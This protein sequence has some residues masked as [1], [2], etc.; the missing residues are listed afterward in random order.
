[1]LLVLLAEIF[2]NLSKPILMATCTNVLCIVSINVY[3][4]ENLCIP[5]LNVVFCLLQGLVYQEFFSQGDLE[6]ALGKNP[7]EMMDREK[8]CIPELQISFLDNIAAPVYR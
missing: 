4:N 2:Y 7:L 6:K 8:A 5:N 1:M 3:V